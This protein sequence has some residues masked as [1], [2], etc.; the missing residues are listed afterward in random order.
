[1]AVT[2]KVVAEMFSRFLNIELDDEVLDKLV[3][4]IDRVE[5]SI[6]KDLDLS[7]V[8]GE[9]NLKAL[10]GTL[11]AYGWGL[12]MHPYYNPSVDQEG[13]RRG[14]DLPLV[15]E[16]CDAVNVPVTA[17][18]GFGKLEDLTAIEPTG[19]A[20]VA[21]A[22]ALHWKRMTLAG[23]KAHAAA[24]GLDVRQGVPA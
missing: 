18:G 14:F 20:G 12:G 16:V 6:R 5:D 11:L 4:L 10:L 22:D 8:Q 3:A 15:Q 17:S 7:T 24:A 23:I 21:I 19:V 2:R 9:K 1:M 13:T